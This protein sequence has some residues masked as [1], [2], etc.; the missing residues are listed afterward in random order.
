[1][2]ESKIAWKNVQTGA[3]EQEPSSKSV[4][5][6]AQLC[7]TAALRDIMPEVSLFKPFI[8]SSLL[9]NELK[10]G[11]SQSDA[12]LNIQLKL[13]LFYFS[14]VCHSVQFVLY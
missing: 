14:V 5:Y 7:Q 11:C 4:K 2:K 3:A 9:W 8:H 1:M 13:E 10:T 12:E 6:I